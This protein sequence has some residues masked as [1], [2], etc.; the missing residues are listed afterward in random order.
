MFVED[1]SLY[2][3]QVLDQFLWPPI[4]TIKVKEGGSG[5]RREG[6]TRALPV[7][8]EVNRLYATRKRSQSGLQ[9]WRVRAGLTIHLLSGSMQVQLEGKPGSNAGFQDDHS[10]GLGTQYF[11]FF[12]PNRPDSRL[13]HFESHRVFGF[14][15]FSLLAETTSSRG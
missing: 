10:P 4:C 8:S 6:C 7:C 13:R 9:D 11:V 3:G 1:S 14:V 12:P 5:T 15:F 2:S